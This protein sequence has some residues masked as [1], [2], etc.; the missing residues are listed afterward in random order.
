MADVARLVNDSNVICSDHRV[1]WAVRRND[2]A[3][4]RDPRPLPP[5]SDMS[6]HRG[7]TDPW[8]EIG[9]CMSEFM[10]QA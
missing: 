4:M 3:E 2:V 7:E 9:P 5:A 10:R 1:V 6:E 8:S